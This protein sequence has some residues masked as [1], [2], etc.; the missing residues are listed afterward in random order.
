MRQRLLLGFVVLSLGCG[1]GGQGQ[2][3]VSLTPVKGI[4]TVDGKPEFGVSLVL[5]PKEQ[6]N[7]TAGGAGATDAEGNV[8][9]KYRDGRDGMPPGTYS[10]VATWVRMPDGS[11]VP[12][13][14]MP[15]NVGAKNLLNNEYSNPETT[16]FTVTVAEGVNEPVKVDLF[17]AGKKK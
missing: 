17:R 8:T 14:A 4:V 16:P 9:F 2:D 13:D 3:D 6:G 10:M 15:E 12:P 11:A 1:G 7:Q 5:I